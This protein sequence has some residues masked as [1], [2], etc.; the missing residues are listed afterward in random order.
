MLRA[1]N[2][3]L[4]DTTQPAGPTQR[5]EAKL[6]VIMA[7]LL[8]PFPELPLK[9]LAIDTIADRNGSLPFAAGVPQAAF[10]AA[11]V[12]LEQPMTGPRGRLAEVGGWHHGGIN[13]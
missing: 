8:K 13:D 10:P 12:A 7:H 2:K 5:N 4:A 6:E 11:A 9:L 3:R 1:N